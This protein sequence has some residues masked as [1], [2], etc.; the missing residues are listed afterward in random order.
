M[1]IGRPRCPNCS[2]EKRPQW[3]TGPKSLEGGAGEGESP[4]VPGPCRTTRRCRRVGLFG[5]AAPIGRVLEIVG[6]EADGG[7]R[8]AS[9][10]CGTARA[11]PPI[12]SGHGPTRIVMVAQARAV[13]MLVET[14]SSRLWLEAR[15]VSLVPSEVSLRIAGARGEFYRDGVA[16]SLRPRNREPKLAMRD[17]RKLVTVPTGANRPPGV[18]R[19]RQQD[20][21]MESNP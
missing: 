12:D 10:G 3:R 8:C 18:G 5:N 16:A 20:G 19:L 13:D 6:R 4:V 9:V 17:E 11:G 7:R 15:A 14:S 2:L 21:V 1:R